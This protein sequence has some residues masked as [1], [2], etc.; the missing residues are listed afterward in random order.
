MVAMQVLLFTVCSFNRSST[1]TLNH[2]GK[3][4]ALASLD[5]PYI[6]LLAIEGKQYVSKLALLITLRNPCGSVLFLVDVLS[7]V[8][9]A[10]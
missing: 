1:V 5:D 3:C 2:I 10:P 6:K 7:S 8:R 9:I 4:Y